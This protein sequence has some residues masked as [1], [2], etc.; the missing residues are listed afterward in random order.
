M[1]CKYILVNVFRHVFQQESRTAQW[2][3][4][5]TS[6]SAPAWASASCSSRA[7]SSS[8]SPLSS[9]K[10]A[11]T[12]CTSTADPRAMTRTASGASPSRRIGPSRHAR[13]SRRN[14]APISKLHADGGFL[15]LEPVAYKVIFGS[16]ST[17]NSAN[18]PR[19]N[20]SRATTAIMAAL[21]VHAFC[22]GTVTRMPWRPSFSIII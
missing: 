12:R 18:S 22:G 4:S 21:S 10:S 17:V 1:Q 16:A 13:L 19:K 8:A 9:W 11:P 15:S 3:S 7:S 5:S 14:M 2:T 6:S 20:F